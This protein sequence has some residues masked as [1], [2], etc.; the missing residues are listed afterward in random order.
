[1]FL[2][3]QCLLK[4]NCVSNTSLEVGLSKVAFMGLQAVQYL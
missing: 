3:S 1:M 4:A 2:V